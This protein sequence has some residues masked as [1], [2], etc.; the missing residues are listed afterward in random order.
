MPDIGLIELLLI[1]VVGFLVIGPDKLPEFMGQIASIVR[2]GRAW[3]TSLRMQL[4]QEKQSIIA[5]VKEIKEGLET[6]IQ[7][8]VKDANIDEK[9]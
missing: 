1:A 7:D 8:A 2:Q 3:M 9:D 4:E 6:S 5:P